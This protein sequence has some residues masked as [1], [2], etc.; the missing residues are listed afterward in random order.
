MSGDHRAT[1]GAL[2]ARRGCG[3]AVLRVV[4]ARMRMPVGITLL[5]MLARP[6]FI[7]RICRAR[8]A[9]FLTRRV[10]EAPRR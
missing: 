1:L 8:E 6:A 5:I 2:D 7:K 9:E 3:A 4:K 10:E